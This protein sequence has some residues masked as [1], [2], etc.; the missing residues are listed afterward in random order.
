MACRLWSQVRTNTH[1]H[2]AHSSIAS[3]PA[4]PKGATMASYN[5][6]ICRLNDN[7]WVI[8]IE[9]ASTSSGTPLV[10]FPQKPNCYDNQ[11]WY[12]EQSNVLN[13][14][15]SGNTYWYFF[16]NKGTDRVITVNGNSLEAVTQK[17]TDNDDQL[18][19]MINTDQPTSPEYY[20]I[21]NKKDNLVITIP[22]ST[23]KSGVPLQMA[24]LNNNLNQQW[25]LQGV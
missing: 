10:N 21:Q 8:D 22:G 14:N 12:Q 4:S 19:E 16:K 15:G 6:M 18:W 24:A 2:R 1:P 13:T 25:F 17:T 9:G 11:L 7:E 5:F 23:K 20:Y 3:I